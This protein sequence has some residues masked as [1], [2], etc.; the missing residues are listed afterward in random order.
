MSSKQDRAKAGDLERVNAE[1]TASLETCRKLLAECR[2]KL[3]ANANDPTPPVA[4]PDE[5]RSS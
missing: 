3:A 2:S 1:L 4:R 5:E